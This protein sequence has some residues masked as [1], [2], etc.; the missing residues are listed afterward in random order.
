MKYRGLPMKKIKKLLPYIGSIILLFISLVVG[1]PL[2]VLSAVLLACVVFSLLTM[3]LV[4]LP[5][6]LY[7]SAFVVIVVVL[8]NIRKLPI[9]Y[10]KLIQPVWWIT[11]ISLLS[12]FG[13]GCWEAIS[14]ENFT[15]TPTE[16]YLCAMIGVILGVVSVSLPI[17]IGNTSKSLV[18]YQNK[19]IAGIFKKEVAYKAM[20]VFVIPLLALSLFLFFF[21]HNPV[22]GKEEYIWENRIAAFILTSCIYSICLFT[23][24]MRRFV[25][26]AINTDEVILDRIGKAIERLKRQKGLSSLYDEYAEVYIQILMKKGKEQ[27]YVGLNESFKS[28]SEYVTVIIKEIRKNNYSDN[29]EGAMR[30]RRFLNKYSQSFFNIWRLVYADNP[31]YT[32]YFSEEYERII[33]NALEHSDRDVYGQLLSAYQRIAFEITNEE[34]EAI[35]VAG[36]ISWEWFFNIVKDGSF[37]VS[38]IHFVGIYLFQVM[39]AIVKRDNVVSFNLFVST[40]VDGIWVFFNTN[41]PSSVRPYNEKYYIVERKTILMYTPAEYHELLNECKKMERSGELS[42]LVSKKFALNSISLIVAMVGAYC[43]FKGK[44]KLVNVI[45][46]YNQPKNANIQYLNEDISPDNIDVLLKWMNDYYLFQGTYFNLWDDHNDGGFWFGKYISLL[47]YRIYE[48]VNNWRMSVS[49]DGK[50][51]QDLEADKFNLNKIKDYINA[52]D[53]TI[54][55]GCGLSTSS[56]QAVVQKIESLIVQLTVQQARVQEEQVLDPKKVDNFKKMVHSYITDTTPWVNVFRTASSENDTAKMVEWAFVVSENTIIEK[57]FL[58]EQDSGIYSGFSH[59]VAEKM[60]VKFAFQLERKLR[61]FAQLNPV[62]IN[63]AGYL[64]KSDYKK[65]IVK[66]YGY[67]VV[68]VN[69]YKVYDFLSPDDFCSVQDNGPM[70]RIKGGPVIYSIGDRNDETSRMIVFR[71]S[72]FTMV[73]IK[74]T[75]DLVVDLNK[76]SS[77]MKFLLKKMRYGLLRIAPEEREAYLRRQVEIHFEYQF[78]LHVKANA[79]I[80]LLS[81]I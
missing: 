26:Y 39:K 11:H 32:Y 20:F 3:P 14:K 76:K 69:Y 77:R 7:I 33:K 58:A 37:D 74:Q 67:I 4:S 45:F 16:N 75:K 52:L 12:L 47:F 21:F 71:A 24:F 65:K 1:T 56:R 53:E 15:L 5:V 81:N 19:L 31:I 42:S 66:L 46:E 44:Y 9:R 60:I 30:Y 79:E 61:T 80:Q 49:Y 72:D 50:N 51:G 40:I 43:L 34:A 2:G 68:F 29:Y 13:W 62:D 48:N 70:A 27:S 64:T 59:A 55:D 57:S 36:T 54:I 17:I 63:S 18:E 28:L 25:E 8:K 10:L 22:Y 6:I 41:Y 35:P 78:T 38:K 73:N 23:Y